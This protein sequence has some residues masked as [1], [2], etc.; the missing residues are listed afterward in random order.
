MQGGGKSYVVFVG[1][2][3]G[4]YGKWCDCRLQ[5]NGVKHNSYKSFFSS[6][7]AEEAFSAAQARG[8]TYSCG[9][10]T[11]S[12][13]RVT[14][15]ERMFPDSLPL[16]LAFTDDAASQAMS[17]AGDP[18]YVVVAGTQPGVYRTFHEALLATTGLEGAKHRSFPSRAQAQR[19]MKRALDNGEVYRLSRG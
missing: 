1:R 2:T 3:A 15:R 16:C 7:K 6:E 13:G 17:A 9:S 11:I 8:L 14:G 19:E 5:V 10:D 12:V 18:W 4:V